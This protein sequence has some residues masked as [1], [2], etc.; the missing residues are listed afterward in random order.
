MALSAIFDR[1]MNLAGAAFGAARQ[2]TQDLAGA[3]WEKFSRGPLDVAGQQWSQPEGGIAG[4]GYGM[5]E[6]GLAGQ[7]YGMPSGGLAGQGYGTPRG[8]LAGGGSNPVMAMQNQ[9]SAQAAAAFWKPEPVAK[10][11]AGQGGAGGSVGNTGATGASGWL[12]QERS[13]SPLIPIADDL[14][15]YAVAKGVDPGA[16]FG[17]LRKES[18]YGADGALGI[19]N[20]NPGNIMAAGADPANGKIILQQFATLLDGAKAIVDLL[21]GY[22]AT[23]GAKTLEDMIAIYY[24]GPQ[25]YARYGLNANDAGGQG[26]GG[27]GTVQQYLEQHVYPV[28]QS[29]NARVGAAT[30]PTSMAR[31]GLDTMFPGVD[32]P[33]MQGFGHT[34]YSTGPGAS[35]YD[36][37]TEFGLDGD[38]HTGWDIGVP[39]GTAFHMPSG[40]T[41]VVTVAG[42]SGYYKS[43]NGPDGAGRGELRIKLSNGWELILGHNDRIDVQVGQQV[44][45]GMLLGLTGSSDGDHIHIE[46]RRPSQ[47]RTRSGWEI[48]DPALLF[49]GH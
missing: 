36:F 18:Q 20:N 14:A 5:P 37:G 21:A 38:E 32:L 39:R 27:N 47:G 19:Q 16:V 42:G 6:G 26:P 15:A 43:N 44:T 40:L 4:Q 9:E 46:V 25:A 11:S 17:L 49:G 29:Y 8:G 1:A 48:V 31:S 33:M 28:M 34:D 7:G 41:G 3:G 2:G 30:D 12:A 24:V 22:G 23:Y 45:A 35:V 13:D 10:P